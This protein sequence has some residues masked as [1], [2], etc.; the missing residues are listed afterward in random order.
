MLD[1]M[2]HTH[3]YTYVYYSLIPSTHCYGDLRE[4]FDKLLVNVIV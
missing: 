2:T 3:L 4:L 1:Q